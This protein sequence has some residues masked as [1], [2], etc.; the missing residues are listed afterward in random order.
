MERR[1]LQKQTW[2]KPHQENKRAEKHKKSTHDNVR[3]N[4]GENEREGASFYEAV[5]ANHEKLKKLT[6]FKC[7]CFKKY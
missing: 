1:E 7:L 4:D 2:S 3:K 6:D 5:W